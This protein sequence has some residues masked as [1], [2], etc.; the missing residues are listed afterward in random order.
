L[1]NTGYVHKS[2]A[3]NQAQQ[4]ALNDDNN[5][6]KI[7]LDDISALQERRPELVSDEVSAKDVVDTDSSILRFLER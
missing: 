7:L 3:G 1:S 5:L 2:T 4:S 6:F